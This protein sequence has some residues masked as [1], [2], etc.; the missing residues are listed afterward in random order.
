ME[1]CLGNFGGSGTAARS[2]A[3]HPPCI[4]EHQAGL[5][6]ARPPDPYPYI[7]LNL[8][9]SCLAAL[10]TPLIMMSRKRQESRD[11]QH[12]Q[13]DYQINRKAE[14]EIRHLHEKI[15]HLLHHHSERLLEIQQI[16]VALLRQLLAER[17][18][19]RSCL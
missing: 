18:P 3:I 11:R 2:L 14:L 17:K 9:L 13:Q 4:K 8:M 15:A 5:L 12:A 19:G 6:A 1:I 10:Q 16:Q 7:L